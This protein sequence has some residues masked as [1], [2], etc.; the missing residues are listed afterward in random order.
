ML[1]FSGRNHLVSP[2]GIP[3]LR[4]LIYYSNN[5]QNP[6]DYCFNCPQKLNNLM[7]TRLCTI[8]LW[9]GPP[10]GPKLTKINIELGHG[11]EF[12]VL[13]KYNRI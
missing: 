4:I 10:T 13:Y 9:E 7:K 8:D 6:V 5:K 1:V 11:S 12:R 3:A 2:P